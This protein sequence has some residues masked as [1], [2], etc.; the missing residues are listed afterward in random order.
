MN[1][2]TSGDDCRSGTEDFMNESPRNSS[3]KPIISSPIFLLLLFL[4]IE[5]MNPTAI[6]GMDSTEMS[7]VKPSREMIQ[8][9]T[10]VPIFAPIITP[11]ACVRVSSPAFT[12]LTTITVVALEDWMIAVMLRPVSTLLK[13]FDVMAARKD[14]SLSPAAF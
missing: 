9:V 4:D 6:S 1:E 14:L 13:G 2:R 5:H 11:T 8:A 10:V 7:A 12:K 3:E